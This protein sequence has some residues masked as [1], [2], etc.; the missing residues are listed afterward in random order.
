[1]T[2]QGDKALFRFVEPLGCII[3]C[4]LRR[5]KVVCRLCPFHIIASDGVARSKQWGTV[6]AHELH[7]LVPSFA[8]PGPLVW[9]G[10]LLQQNALAAVEDIE[11]SQLGSRNHELVLNLPAIILGDLSGLDRLPDL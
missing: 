4:C 3:G 2:S 9:L 10:S 1:M 5:D 11:M 8:Y 6:P 7:E